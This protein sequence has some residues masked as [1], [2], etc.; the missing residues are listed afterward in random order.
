MGGIRNPVPGG[1]GSGEPRLNSAINRAA[2]VPSG[3]TSGLV[4]W[5]L[6]AQDKGCCED[7]GGWG[8][9]LRV[10]LTSG[11]RGQR[12]LAFAH[13]PN[14]RTIHQTASLGFCVPSGWFGGGGGGAP[15][16]GQRRSSQASSRR[17][18]IIITHPECLF[19]PAGGSRGIF[20]CSPSILID[21]LSVRRRA[22]RA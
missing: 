5:R 12:L 21:F 14:P 6:L 4:C 15:R 22:G 3:W 10:T 1:P 18:V 17:G 7:E 20:S 2:P 13:E 19:C 9:T 11:G 16:D 8:P